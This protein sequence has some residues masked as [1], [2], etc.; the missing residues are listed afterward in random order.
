MI[1]VSATHLVGLY[2]ADEQRPALAALAAR[3]PIDVIHGSI[4][5]YAYP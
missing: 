3:R 2:V 4:Y 5:L 1:A